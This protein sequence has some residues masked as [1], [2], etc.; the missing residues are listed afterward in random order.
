MGRISGYF[1]RFRVH[2][3]IGNECSRTAG[4]TSPRRE[5]SLFRLGRNFGSGHFL[6]CCPVSITLLLTEIFVRIPASAERATFA[7]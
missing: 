2:V 4:T 6:I 3:V 7:G 5:A 1:K